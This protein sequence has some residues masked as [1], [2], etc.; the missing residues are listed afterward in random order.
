MSYENFSEVY[1]IFMNDIPYD[2]WVQHIFE[3]WNKYDVSPKLVAELGCGTGN[4]T[5]RLANKGIEMIGIDVSEEMLIK[6]REKAVNSNILY[7]N[8][9]MREFELFGTVDTVLCLCDSINYI[10]DKSE[11][12]QVF[13]LVDNYLDPRGLFIFDINTVYKFKNILADN[14]FCETNETSAFT[15]E[16][17]YD[18]ED[19]INEYYT[20]F[21]I[22]DSKTNAYNRYEEYHYEKAY[23]I[24][25]IITLIKD[26]GLEFIGVYDELSFN[27]PKKYSQR[28]YFIARECK[29]KIS[30]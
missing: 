4:I 24:D 9:D 15:W 18:D 20:N 7:L 22:K 19:K 14:C 28:V 5:Q 10:L 17:Y 8:Q 27:K 29:K 21:F 11:L 1:D 12:L 3:I 26:A 6:A 13:K 23:E 2:D 30:N 16:N 25:E